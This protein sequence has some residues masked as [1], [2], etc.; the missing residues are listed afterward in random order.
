M[1]FEWTYDTS[2]GKLLILEENGK[3]IGI[4]TKKEKKIVASDYMAKETRV[5]QEAYRQIEEYLQGKRKVFDLPIQMKGTAFQEKV[6]KALC[7]IP[8]GETR[9][10]GEIAKEIGNSK[11]ARAVGMANH[12]NK[13]LIVIPCHRVIGSNHKLVGYAGGIEI[14][15]KLLRL[16]KENK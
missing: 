12:V 5:I 9:S 13:I 6:W 3:I 2:L 1:I 7:N 11:A 8:Y 4:E 10:Y 16:E 14:K 15:E